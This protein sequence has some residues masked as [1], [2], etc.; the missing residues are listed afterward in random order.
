MPWGAR[1]RP[2]RIERADSVLHSGSWWFCSM[3]FILYRRGGSI[4]PP[5]HKTFKPHLFVR[6]RRYSRKLP[7]RVASR[8]PRGRL[9]FSGLPNSAGLGE[10]GLYSLGG[11][12]LG[13]LRLSGEAALRWKVARRWYPRI[14]GLFDMGG[15]V[16]I[17]R[18]LDY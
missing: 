8:I 11:T 12:D 16:H 4:Q 6:T 3:W 18:I 2:W 7:D 14:A 13:R 9:S 5:R 15:R 17:F 1:Q 10:R